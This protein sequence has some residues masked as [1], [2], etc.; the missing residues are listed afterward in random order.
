M[1]CHLII[2]HQHFGERYFPPTSWEIFFLNIHRKWLRISTATK[3]KSF[4]SRENSSCFVSSQIFFEC[5]LPKKKKHLNKNEQKFFQKSWNSILLLKRSSFAPLTAQRPF[6]DG[7]IEEKAVGA[8]H[9]NGLRWV[10]GWPEWPQRLI[11]GAVGKG[12]TVL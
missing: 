2:F 9:P 7:R 11:S 6:S 4:N 10:F 8:F 3:R 5:K 1:M 12:S